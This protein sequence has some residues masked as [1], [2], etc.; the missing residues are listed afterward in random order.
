MAQK[1][2]WR[3]DRKFLPGDS[4][5]ELPGNRRGTVVERNRENTVIVEFDGEKEEVSITSL[6]RLN[7]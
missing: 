2:D 7:Q 1:K 3:T 4:V 6:E 5:L